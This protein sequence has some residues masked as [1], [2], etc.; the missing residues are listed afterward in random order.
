MPKELFDRIQ[1]W[2]RNHCDGEWE[3]D[4]GVKISNVDNP[5]WSVEIDLE[6]TALEKAQFKR[7]FVNDENDNDWLFVEAKDKKFYGSCDT[8][9]L[10][11]VLR[12][13]LDE[14]LPAQADPDFTYT[15]YVP[16]SGNSL[17]VWQEIKAR[18]INESIFEIT[19]IEEKSLKNL[20]VRDINEFSKIEIESLGEHGYKV[21]DWVNCALEVLYEGVKP[22]VSGKVKE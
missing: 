8:S 19:E 21:G 17:S 9:K 10:N 12:I 2:Y 16:L 1:D 6:D 7:H 20:E 14:I 4:Y 22:V 13:F 15:I 18:L 11:E 5:G 3:H